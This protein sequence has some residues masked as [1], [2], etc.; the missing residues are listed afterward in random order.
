[1]FDYQEFDTPRPITTSGLIHYVELPQGKLHSKVT[2]SDGRARMAILLVTIVPG[3][4]RNLLSGITTIIS[5]SAR[6]TRS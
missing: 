5:G 1:M 3:T 2:G 6:I 4:G